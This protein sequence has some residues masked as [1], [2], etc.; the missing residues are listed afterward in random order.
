MSDVLSPILQWLNTH[1]HSAGIGTFIISAMESVAIIGTIVPG[2][3]MMTAIG[4]LVGAGVIPLW[5]TMIWAILGAIV[6]DGISYWIGHY[7]KKRT[8]DIWPFRSYP[9]LLRNGEAFFHRYGGMSVFI[10]R[11][12][13]P[14]RALVPVVAGM[15]GMK[16][17]RFTI[18]N[19]ASAIGWAPAYMLPGIVLGAASLELPPDIAVHVILLLLLATLL[20][21]LCIWLLRTLFI[22]IGHHIDRFLT[23]VWKRLKKS[24]YCNFITT[25][26]RYH[27]PNKNGQ[28]TLAFCLLIT[29]ILFIYLTAYVQ[30]HGSQN[31]VINNAIYY[32][33]RSWRTPTVDKVML[34]ITLLGQVQIIFPVILVLF[35]WLAFTKRWYTAWHVLAIGVLAASSVEIMKCNIHSVRPWGILNNIQDKYSFPSGHT[36]LSATFYL[37]VALL[38]VKTLKLKRTWPIYTFMGIIA[39]SVACSRLY[40]GAHWFTDILGGWLLSAA[41]LMLIALS[42]N[43]NTERPIKVTGIIIT[44]ILTLFITYSVYVDRNFNKLQLAYAPLNWPIRTIELKTWWQQQSKDLPLYRIGRVGLSTELLNLQWI[45]NLAE[46]KNLLIKQGWQTPPALN[47]VTILHRLTDVESAEH[48]PLVEP[49]YFD[50]D[51]VL[52]LVKPVINEKKLLVLRLWNSNIAIKQAK[53]PLWVGSVGFVPRTYSWLFNY[54]KESNISLTRLFTFTPKQYVIKR[55]TV[56][57]SRLIK[58]NKHRVHSRDM[59]LIRPKKIS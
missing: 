5:S 14:V 39:F 49:L 11:F 30:L 51:P 34:Y 9:N 25:A 54:K 37:G 8:H 29:C 15:F 1:P 50:K 3:V 16:P 21:I 55:V 43:R 17:L 36:V 40:L 48:L 27:D 13:G 23:W 56:D 12:V 33:C 28:L 7:F 10:G 42:Y 35:G 46:I 6:G 57:K 31:L 4:T 20:V 53:S 18:A 41:L 38:L 19:T 44:T 26:L 32:L 24:R 2:S 58:H 52:V 47:W 45:G 59:I 22:V